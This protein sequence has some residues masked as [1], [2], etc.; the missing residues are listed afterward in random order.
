MESN[1][2]PVA[3]PAKVTRGHGLL[4]RWLSRERTNRANLLIPKQLREGRVLDIGCGTHP[5]FLA[6]TTF[7]QKFSLD[8][9]AM[10]SETAAHHGITHTTHDLDK[11][12]R[13]PFEDGIFSVVTL[14]AVVEHVEPEVAVQILREAY[15]TLVRGGRLIVTTPAGWAD[16]LLH[17]LAKV[18]LVS[19]E[20]IHEHAFA[21]TLPTLACCLGQA[22]FELKKLQCGSFE[23]W[24]N[25]WAV[26]EK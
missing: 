19:S 16:G 11:D 5:Y 4:E 26:G 22:G 10:P 1:E 7:R 8:Q 24:M 23:L 12:P 14:L 13:L 18:R 3:T 15:R 17:I 9:I 25:L 20:E 2:R 21:Y 6:H